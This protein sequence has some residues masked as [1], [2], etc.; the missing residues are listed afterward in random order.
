MRVTVASQV[1]RILGVD[2][3]SRLLTAVRLYAVTQPESCIYARMFPLVKL[4]KLLVTGFQSI[5]LS[6][7][8]SL[9]TAVTT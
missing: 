9:R 5:M 1:C 7:F 2:S 4:V 3:G 8:S 6:R